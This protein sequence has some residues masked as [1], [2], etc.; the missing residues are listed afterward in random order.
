MFTLTKSDSH[1][2]IQYDSQREISLLISN[3][4]QNYKCSRLQR[5]PVI[6]INNEKIFETIEFYLLNWKHHDEPNIYTS[7]WTKSLEC[8]FNFF[9]RKSDSYTAKLYMQRGTSLFIFNEQCSSICSLPQDINAAHFLK[10][11][12]IFIT[13]DGFKR[14]SFNSVKKS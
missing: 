13:T 14:C 9:P 1:A 6:T 7:I 4:S 3:V 11:L 10:L 12:D 2:A 8:F 5:I